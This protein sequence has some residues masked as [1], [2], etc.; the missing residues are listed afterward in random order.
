MILPEYKSI[1]I[2]IPKTAGQSIENFLLQSLGKS[3][4]EHGADY[5]LK[6]NPTNIGPARL[7]HLSAIEYTALA[8]ISEQD[9][10]KYYTFTFVRNPWARAVSFYKYSGFA[11]LVSFK[12]FITYYLPRLIEEHAW[13]YKPQAK[14]VFNDYNK[15]ELDFVGKFE[16]LETDFA[17]VAKQLKLNFNGLPKDNQSKNINRYSRKSLA[18]VLKYPSVLT[19]LVF[20]INAHPN[21][22]EYYCE[23]TQQKIAELYAIDIK[24]FNYQF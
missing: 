16:Q 11:N 10:K 9:F 18:I 17:Q 6:K 3:R 21:Y 2:H 22:K 24:S 8:Y 1:F 19:R 5:L 23:F 20:K 4:Q 13:F 14:F 12:H 15:N 7:A